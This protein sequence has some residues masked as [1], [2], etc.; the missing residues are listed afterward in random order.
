[1]NVF[2]TKPFMSALSLGEL[3]RDGDEEQVDSEEEANYFDALSDLGHFSGRSDG[4]LDG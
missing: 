4:L 3:D 1:M 2:R